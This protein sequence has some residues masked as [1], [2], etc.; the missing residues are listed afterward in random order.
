LCK[1][2]NR[3]QTEDSQCSEDGFVCHESGFMSPPAAKR[4]SSFA[5]S[6]LEPKSLKPCNPETLKV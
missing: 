3:R 1:T 2:R 6:S 4:L 5:R